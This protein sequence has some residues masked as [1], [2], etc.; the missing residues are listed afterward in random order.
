MVEGQYNGI[1]KPDRHYLELKRDFSNLDEVLVRVK[2]DQERQE[3]VSRA[4]RDIVESG[5]YTYQSFVELVLAKSLN[6]F[7]PAPRAGLRRQILAAWMRLADDLSWTAVILNWYIVAPVRIGLR[8]LLAG[9]FSEERVA[10]TLRRLRR[11]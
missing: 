3:M 7:K 8:R 11:Q 9:L 2:R 10:A 5:L 1:L 4:Y 6:G